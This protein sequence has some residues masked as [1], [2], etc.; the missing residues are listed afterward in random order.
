[1]REIKLGQFYVYKDEDGNAVAVAQMG[2]GPNGG[3]MGFDAA[4]LPVPYGKVTR[5]DINNRAEFMVAAMN[6]YGGHRTAL[7][8]KDAE[9]SRL[10]TENADLLSGE[11]LARVIEERDR[12]REAL[13]MTLSSL[14]RWY[15]HGSP[16]FDGSAAPTSVIGTARGL[17]GLDPSSGMPLKGE[18]S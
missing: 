4:R 8:D 5:E 3:R 18:A 16:E 12:M 6:S 15:R 13:R 9:I 2:V 17:V 1:M 10:T 11:Y 7:A 14:E